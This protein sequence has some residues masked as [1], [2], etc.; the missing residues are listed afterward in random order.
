MILLD[1]VYVVL[2]KDSTASALMSTHALQTGRENDAMLG[3]NTPS[4]AQD[5]LH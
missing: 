2:L 5:L 3:R 1:T 4:N